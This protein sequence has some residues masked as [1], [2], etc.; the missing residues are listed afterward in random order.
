MSFGDGPL[1]VG[2]VEG[3][4]F[5]MDSETLDLG[6]EAGLLR[7]CPASKDVSDLKP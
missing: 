1:E 3:V 6:I 2:V 4:V 5:D 7:D